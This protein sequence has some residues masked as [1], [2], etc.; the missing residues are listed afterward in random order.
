MPM[1][2]FGS[3][4]N[5]QRKVRKGK[6]SGVLTKEKIDKLDVLVPLSFVTDDG[7]K[8]GKWL[9]LQRNAYRN[10]RL[11]NGEYVH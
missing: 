10:G 4:L 6:V 3:W 11:K 1:Y 9:A 7:K 8:L 2:K 5:T